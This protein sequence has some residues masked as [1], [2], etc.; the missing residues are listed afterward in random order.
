MGFKSAFKGLN[1]WSV[2]SRA[3]VGV[4]VSKGDESPESEYRGHDPVINHK[5]VLVR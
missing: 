5:M 3:D 2:A 1:L 4:N